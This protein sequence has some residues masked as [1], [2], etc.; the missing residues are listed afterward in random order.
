MYR[1]DV[2]I[3][4]K[5]KYLYENDDLL[6]I[7]L[8]IYKALKEGYQI[9]VLKDNILLTFLNAIEEFDYWKELVKHK[10]L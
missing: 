2:L 9:R 10:A 3:N 6:K 7:D 4:L 5:W 8:A 1:I